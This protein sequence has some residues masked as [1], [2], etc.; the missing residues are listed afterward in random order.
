V[1][2]GEPIVGPLPTNDPDV[3][4]GKI[5]FANRCYACHPGGEGGLG[6]GLND[7]QLPVFAMK[8]QVRTGIV[9]FG[10]MPSFNAH[11]IPRDDLNDLMKY[12]KATRKHSR[13]LAQ[14]AQ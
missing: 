4:H 3:E 2:R 14:V 9:G 7:K 12:I 10:V 5:V 1:R 13:P 8:L 6:P 11:Q